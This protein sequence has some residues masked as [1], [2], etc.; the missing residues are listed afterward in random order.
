MWRGGAALMLNVLALELIA[1]VMRWETEEATMSNSIDNLKDR[2]RRWRQER[3]AERELAG[4]S[5]AMVQE[6]A[7]DVGLS[8]YELMH[9]PSANPHAAELMP[10]RLEA[11]GLDDK[12]VRAGEPAVHRDMERVCSQCESWRRCER[13][14]AAGD[15]ATGQ[16]TYCGNAGTIEALIEGSG[17]NAHR[18]EPRSRSALNNVR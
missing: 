11:M 4:L 14:M 12:A 5:D 1:D 18:H 10:Q 7:R 17:E 2:V 16:C 9:A 13:D 3:A 8:S 6:T 15:T